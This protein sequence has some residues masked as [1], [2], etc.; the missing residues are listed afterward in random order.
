MLGRWLRQ[1][2]GDRQEIHDSVEKLTNDGQMMD[3]HLSCYDDFTEVPDSRRR[4]GDGGRRSSLT[5]GEIV[6]PLDYSKC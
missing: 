5:P 6:D 2:D 4:D 1:R 3:P